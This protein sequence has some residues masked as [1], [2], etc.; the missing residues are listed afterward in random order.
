MKGYLGEGG[1]LSVVQHWFIGSSSEEDTCWKC[2]RVHPLNK[3]PVRTTLSYFLHLWWVI[4]WCSYPVRRME[5][6]CKYSCQ[7]LLKHD[8][9]VWLHI[10]I[11]WSI[12]VPLKCCTSSFAVDMTWVHEAWCTTLNH[13]GIIETRDSA[14]VVLCSSNNIISA[15]IWLIDFWSQS[16]HTIVTTHLITSHH[17]ISGLFCNHHAKLG[18]VCHDDILLRSVWFDISATDG[19]TSESDLSDK[20]PRA[21][22]CI[23]DKFWGM[24]VR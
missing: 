20:G 3:S 23:G 17:R 2:H 6:V 9:W 24:A 14:D 19:L 8:Y 18:K 16:D 21:C 10:K 15:I 12:F 11:L 5:A 7:H 13:N 1:E 22:R 4:L